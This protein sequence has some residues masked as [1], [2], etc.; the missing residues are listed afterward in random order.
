MRY[1]PYAPTPTAKSVAKPICQVSICSSIARV[2]SPDDAGR[3]EADPARE[4]SPH[5]SGPPKFVAAI[6]EKGRVGPFDPIVPVAGRR[7]GGQ[8]PI[9]IQ[10]RYGQAVRAAV[11][12]PVERIEGQVDPVAVGEKHQISE[13]AVSLRRDED[14]RFRRLH[15]DPLAEHVDPVRF[16]QEGGH[17]GDKID[18]IKIL[19]AV[20]ASRKGLA[21]EPLRITARPGRL[22]RRPTEGATAFRL[23]FSLCRI[24]LRVSAVQNVSA[25]VRDQM[26]VE[27]IIRESQCRFPRTGP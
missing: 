20:P 14:G 22:V 2:H 17:F 16:P 18:D 19:K 10:Q 6:A 27:L 21:R 1:F 9:L 8:Q 15:H 23:R 13:M 5:R 11:R 26:H 25:T 3:R 4:I 7:K 12:N 24:L